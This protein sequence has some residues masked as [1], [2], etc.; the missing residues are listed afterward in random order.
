M[1][2]KDLFNQ[3][4]SEETITKLEIFEKYTEAWLPVFLYRNFKDIFIC[5]FFAGAGYDKIGIP[6]SPLRILEVIKSQQYNIIKNRV[7]INVLF[8]ELDKDKYLLLEKNIIEK[9]EEMP[10]LRDYLKVQIQNKE[11]YELFGKRKTDFVKSAN[12]FFLDQ[13]G[14]KEIS[15]E[16]F[17][18]L[19]NLSTTDFMFF[20]SSSFFHRFQ[21]EGSK[22]FKKFNL[23]D[24]KGYTYSKIHKVILELYKKMIPEENST[25]LYPFTI[26]KGANIYGLIFGA[27]HPRAVDKFLKIAWD[28]NKLN[29]QANFDMDKE[30][31]NIQRDLFTNQGQTKVEKYELELGKFILSKQEITNKELYDFTL[32][33]GHI[34]KHTIDKVKVMK[35][36]KIIDYYGHPC[37]SY[38]KCY[39]ERKREIKTF[40]VIGNE[41][42]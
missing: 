9:L 25:K 26:K 16:V 1:P 41:K 17:S 8:N 28:K 4:F 12:L 27:K 6:G 22:Y 32:E 10:D 19:V 34:P 31:E 11:F 40:K 15:E 42:N 30:E 23:H 29:G 38:A 24:I 36:E 18:D 20:V 39:S 2:S 14:V 3:P 33:N 35:K 13:N 5:D 21:N 37:I 7:T